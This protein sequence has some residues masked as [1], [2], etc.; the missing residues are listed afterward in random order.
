MW[1]K[2]LPN[3]SQ[4][5]TNGLLEGNE[6]WMRPECEV[7]DVQN[8]FLDPH[9]LLVWPFHASFLNS[10]HLFSSNAIAPVDLATSNTLRQW[11]GYLQQGD[12]A[13]GRFSADD[14]TAPVKLTCGT[15]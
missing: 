15:A 8:P 7:S 14:Q 12:W 2:G 4:V 3:L 13:G 5:L 6:V 11:R 10:T 1:S 9:I